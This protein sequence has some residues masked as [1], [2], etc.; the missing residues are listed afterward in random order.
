MLVQQDR[1]A[2]RVQKRAARRAG[3]GL[4]CFCLETDPACFQFLLDLAHILE[5]FQRI[6]VGIPAGIEGQYVFLEH[7]LEQADNAVT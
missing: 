3:G 7:A 2:I 1:I 4:V 5:V 6:A